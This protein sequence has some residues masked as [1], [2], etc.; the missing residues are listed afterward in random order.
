MMLKKNLDARRSWREEVSM[1]V[2]ATMRS[3]KYG[4]SAGMRRDYPMSR[5]TLT[6]QG[7]KRDIARY[8]WQMFWIEAC[9]AGILRPT[10]MLFLDD[11]SI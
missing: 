5:A 4:R 2:C 10:V 1:L 8:T 7:Y 3:F 11:L 6:F 9:V